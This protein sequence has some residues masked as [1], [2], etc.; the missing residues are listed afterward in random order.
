MNKV[1]KQYRT[2]TGHRLNNYSGKCSHFH[3]HSYLWEVTVE[4]EHLSD[5]GMVVDFKDLKTA[6]VEVLEPLDHAMVLHHEDPV[7][8]DNTTAGLYEIFR[9][10]NGENPRLFIWPI[11][12]TAENFAAWASLEIQRL[13]P[14]GKTVTHVRV[15]ETVNSYATWELE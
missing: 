9:A 13:L 1:T 5:N 2:E 12:P 3:G 14:V 6:M 4:T 8:I 15:W 11:N 10:T 7:V